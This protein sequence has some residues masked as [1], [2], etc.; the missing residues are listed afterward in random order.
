M[1]F[2]R[3]KHYSENGFTLVEVL[4]ALCIT[5]VFGAAVFA[6]NSRILLSLKSQREATAATM[7]LQE[8]M[9]AFRSLSYTQVATNTLAY[10]SA[11]PK[12]VACFS[13]P[14]SWPT[15]ARC[16]RS[17][18]GGI[19]GSLQ[20]TITVSGYMDT[21]GTLPST[22]NKNVWVRNSSNTTGSL[23]TSNSTLATDYDLLK[24]DIKL[25]WNSADGRPRKREIAEIFGHG[26]MGN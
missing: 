20:E 5:V 9:E 6:T 16:L 21:S 11:V 25:T 18:L 13:L 10:G 17:Q 8:H 2:T 26:N 24:V 19:T 14:T 22:P 12:P 3:R 23:T 15:T 7:M 1:L 4:V